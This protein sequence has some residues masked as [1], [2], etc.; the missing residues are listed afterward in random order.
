MF[1]R[2]ISQSGTA[3]CAWAYNADPEGSA[4]GFAKKLACTGSK[5][6]MIECLRKVEP[7]D[8][9]KALPGFLR[10][11]VSLWVRAIASYHNDG[12]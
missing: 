5:K 10:P 9:M 2:A 12:I 3:A 6:E 11:R 1:H 8:V 7:A 4:A